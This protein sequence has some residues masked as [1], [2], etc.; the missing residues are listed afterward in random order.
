MERAAVGPVIALSLRS[1]RDLRGARDTQK[2]DKAQTYTFDIHASQ[3]RS[4]LSF[5]QGRSDLRHDP[6]L[7]RAWMSRYPLSGQLSR[8]TKK[9]LQSHL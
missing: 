1:R 7:L 5:R 6:S 4:T 2:G 9:S 3:F 8:W